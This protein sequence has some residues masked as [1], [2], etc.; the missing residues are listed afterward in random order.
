MSVAVNIVVT[1]TDSKKI[2]PEKS[3]KLS[4]CK[5]KNLSD[6]FGEWIEHIKLSDK[7]FIPKVSAIELYSGGV[8]S[9]AKKLPEL[10]KNKGIESFYIAEYGVD[11]FLK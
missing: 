10:A 5:S 11:F 1:C 9:I 3:L 4:S 6:R 2:K 8:W 7:Y